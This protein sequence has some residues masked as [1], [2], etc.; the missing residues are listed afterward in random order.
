M[1]KFDILGD[2]LV[3]HKDWKQLAWSCPK[4]EKAYQHLQRSLINTLYLVCLNQNASRWILLP[5]DQA[6]LAV[7]SLHASLSQLA[8][9]SIASY[10]VRDMRLVSISSLP[11]MLI[12]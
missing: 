9:D 2:A 6:R 12:V 10:L 7:S 3:W 5:L 4:V 11:L 1:E 8:A